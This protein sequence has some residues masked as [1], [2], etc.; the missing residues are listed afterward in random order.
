MEKRTSEIGEISGP[1]LVFGGIYSN[2]QALEE[3][4]R[5][6]L[7]LGIPASN[8]ICTGDV[9]AYCAQ[10]DECVEFVQNWGIH[11][12]AG[13]V[14]I[15]L[16]NGEDD[17]GCNFGDGTRCDLFSRLWF[18]FAQQSLSEKSIEWMHQLPD[19]LTLH[20]AGR[21]V[22]VVH[23]SVDETAGYI[24][25]STPWE[26]KE[27]QMNK[28]NAEVVLAGHCGI[29][30]HSSKGEKAWINS[31][32]IG[33]PANDG[34]DRVWYCLLNDDNGLLAEHRTF[35]YDA[36][37]TNSRMRENQLPSEYAKTLLTGLWDSMDILPPTEAANQGVRIDIASLQLR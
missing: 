23:G 8:V 37:E 22:G 7:E 3:M 19:Y 16:R 4:H 26:E 1:L 14:E 2:L 28:L 30:F 11:C 18:P 9:V 27:G 35:E 12:I 15:Q 24:F 29:P 25:E 33:M 13:N 36:H 10:P 6:A 20:Y 17:C 5:I 21:K 34:T 31:G 32:A